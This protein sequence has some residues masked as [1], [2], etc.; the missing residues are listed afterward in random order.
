MKHISSNE[1]KNN[2]FVDRFNKLSLKELGMELKHFSIGTAPETPSC[3]VNQEELKD[4]IKEK[5]A[6]FFDPDKSQGLEIVF[7]KSD[8]G[9]GKSHFI[10]SIFSFL[11]NYDNIITKNISLKQEATDIKKTILNAFGKRI[12]IDYASSLLDKLSDI[13]QDQNI[14]ILELQERF[15]ISP[16]IAKLIYTIS[17]DP[18]LSRQAKAISIFN[19]AYLKEYLK[20]FQIKETELN[21]DF[22]SGIIKLLCQ[23]MVEKNT[24]AVIIVDE[25]EHI[26]N[27]KNNQAR[28]IFYSDLKELWDNIA[29]F[30]NLFLLFAESEAGQDNE[31]NEDPAFSSRKK[32]NTFDIKKITSQS[33]I[34]KLLA[35]IKKRYYKYYEINLDIYHNDILKDLKDC[36]N[37]KTSMN[38]RSYT[39]AIMNILNNY[40][41]KQK[42]ELKKKNN[43]T[44]TLFPVSNN[45]PTNSITAQWEAATSITKKTLLCD[46]FTHILKK[47]NE[48][49]LGIQK[50][51]GEIN[52]NNK[53]YTIVVTDTPNVKD[54]LK[55]YE[56]A[57][58][59]IQIGK[60]LLFLY[61]KILN[62]AADYSDVMF[63]NMYDMGKR[64]ELLYSQKKVYETTDE[65]ISF[66]MGA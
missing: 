13:E 15:S 42:K 5:L 46:A 36:Q 64:L 38:Y 18:D 33:D 54:F 49:I 16:L 53:F 56:I 11:Q 40:R 3:L 47:K 45:I 50:K 44:M 51:T 25:Y 26:F 34:E 7:L 52:T 61:P 48:V 62:Y 43:I 57:K 6:I 4:K 59:K 1:C 35:M 20:E 19:G 31:N 58:S 21:R 41:E 23:Y 28:R 63:Y 27:W 37:L 30:N 60:S 29:S 65:Y 10:R 8:Y 22:Y 32:N 2:I 55:R 12:I 9:N 39:Q 14:L 66:L 17:K 24:Y